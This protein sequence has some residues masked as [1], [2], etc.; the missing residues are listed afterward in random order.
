[1]VWV[2]PFAN[3]TFESQQLADGKI[4]DI[5]KDFGLATLKHDA[6]ILLAYGKDLRTHLL[7]FMQY[8]GFGGVIAFG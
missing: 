3:R 1:M 2:Q 6:R 8:F 4:E 5:L 7:L